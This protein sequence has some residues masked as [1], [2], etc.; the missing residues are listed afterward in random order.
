MNNLSIS[1]VV[2]VYSGA[3]YLEELV[4]EISNVRNKLIEDCYPIKLIEAIFVN[5][6]AIDNSG[7]VLEIIAQKYDWIRTIE[8]SRNYG[9][10][11]ATMLG[12]LHSSG[13][14]IV[15]LDEDLQHHPKYIIKL[16]K[17]AIQKQKD[18][19]YAH[20]EKPV[21]GSFMRDLGSRGI[22]WILAKLT[23]EPNIVL[24]NS[25]RMMRGDIARGAASVSMNQTYFDLALTWFTTKVT[26]LKLPLKDQ[27][28]L[29]S[30]K[31][32]YSFHS[33]LS[34]SLRMIQTSNLKMMRY[35]LLLG[36][37]SILV[38]AF[39]AFHTL[40][41]KLFYPETIG[42]QG[43]ASLMIAILF[44]GGMSSLINGMVLENQSIMLMR[45]HGK[46]SFFV[47][48]RSSDKILADFFKTLGENDTSKKDRL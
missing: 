28:Y 24:F 43:W 46:P 5:D 27:R 47:I 22:K 32:G 15:T 33:L 7:E 36:I 45:S 39:Y 30:K 14:W 18:V 42:V 31:S 13:D 3:E 11:P 17:E 34:H 1:V 10:H 37:I 9:Q 25:Y 48:D 12:I 44:L 40:I 29:S 16:L 41:M 35:G 6:S 8:L 20:P 21:H 38:A 26:S 2:P 19:V 4:V 23:S